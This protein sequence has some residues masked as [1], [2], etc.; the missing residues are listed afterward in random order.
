MDIAE[1]RK[2]WKD[3]NPNKSSE[4]PSYPLGWKSPDKRKSSEQ[5]QKVE[6]N[7]YYYDKCDMH[8]DMMMSK[9]QN[10]TAGS[11]TTFFNDFQKIHLENMKN[12]HDVMGEVLFNMAF[13][14]DSNFPYPIRFMHAFRRYTC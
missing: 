1:R 6:Y 9:C 12:I 8:M 10:L 13:G 7:V 14:K 3:E 11:F 2:K 5:D 4:D